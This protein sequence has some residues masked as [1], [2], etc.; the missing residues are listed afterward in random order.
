MIDERIFEEVLEQPWDGLVGGLV[1]PD[2][3]S[4]SQLDAPE[5]EEVMENLEKNLG[6]LLMTGG[7][8]E[9]PP[10][11]PEER[12]ERLR[13]ALDLSDDQELRA[14]LSSLRPVKPREVTNELARKIRSHKVQSVDPSTVRTYLTDASTI[15]AHFGRFKDTAVPPIRL[16]LWKMLSRALIQYERILRGKFKPKSTSFPPES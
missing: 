15:R 16:R 7:Q 12:R 4:T 13:K 11:R 6:F 1:S 9:D 8:E 3:T 5:L 2:S 10:V 14:L